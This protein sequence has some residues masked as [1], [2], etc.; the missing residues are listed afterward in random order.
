MDSGQ[1]AI[2]AFALGV[3]V[4]ATLGEE[5]M[6]VERAIQLD[7]LQQK[8]KETIMSEVYLNIE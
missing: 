7:A 5:H 8:G 2:L 3:R 1:P 6:D 4:K